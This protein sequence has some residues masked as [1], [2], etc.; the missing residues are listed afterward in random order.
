MVKKFYALC[1]L[2]AFGAIS[3]VAQAA[4]GELGEAAREIGEE[5]AQAAEE[6]RSEM[7]EMGKDITGAMGDLR[8]SR[9]REA[10]PDLST[11]AGKE[12]DE[13]KPAKADGR[14][15]I[16]NLTGSVHVVGWDRNEVR[17]KGK[18]GRGVE[19]FEFKSSP[20]RTIIRVVYP[21][22]RGMFSWRS[23]RSEP[24]YLTVSVPAASTVVVHTVSADIRAEKLLGELDLKSVSGNVRVSDVR[25]D[26]RAHTVSGEIRAEKVL[27]ELDLVSVS[28]TVR[29]SDAAGEVEAR[30]VSGR[31][32]LQQISPKEI[33]PRGAPTGGMRANSVSGG[34]T[35]TGAL[36]RDVR[37]ECLSGRIRVE[38][39]FVEGGEADLN[40]HSGSVTIRADNL[41]NL[42]AETMSGNL[43]VDGTRFAPDARVNL[44]AHSGAISM[45]LPP[46]VAGRF[47]LETFSGNI[48]TD[49]TPEGGLSL[50]GRGPGKRLS[51]SVGA[52]NARISAKSFSGSITL[53]TQ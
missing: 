3:T 30:T 48:T 34:I 43:R 49:I 10:P 6:I 32:E 11:M 19:R 42:D 9:V 29:A 36:L 23:R 46:E 45:T 18:I 28:G 35:V 22:S 7:E 12:V 8:E 5:L 52:G 17:V 13:T 50:K 27:G 25:N 40:S 2:A 1:L 14:V 26:I 51:F 21:R 44:E 47:D 20:G 41:A 39:T 53:K 15:Q 31:I 37:C 33:P 38:G 4:M 16:D 24:S